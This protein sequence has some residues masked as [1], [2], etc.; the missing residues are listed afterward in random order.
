MSGGAQQIM[1]ANTRNLSLSP[2]GSEMY[3][4]TGH[5]PRK[6]PSPF[7]EPGLLAKERARFRGGPPSVGK[8]RVRGALLGVQYLLPGHRGGLERLCVCRRPAPPLVERERL[9]C[10]WASFA[11]TARIG[12]TACH[13]LGCFRREDWSLGGQGQVPEPGQS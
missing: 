1:P 12:Y 4:R 10:P 13:G 6:V 9:R 5:R 3:P 11:G 2:T 7:P 8:A